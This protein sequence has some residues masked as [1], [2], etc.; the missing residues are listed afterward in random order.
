MMHWPF[1]FL[2]VARAAIERFV[3]SVRYAGVRKRWW[4]NGERWGLGGL[5]DY[6]VWAVMLVST[7]FIHWP[8]SKRVRDTKGLGWAFV[9]TVALDDYEEFARAVTS[10]L[11]VARIV[12]A[13]DREIVVDVV[14]EWNRL[15]GMRFALLRWLSFA[16]ERFAVGSE[17]VTVPGMKDGTAKAYVLARLWAGCMQ[18]SKIIENPDIDRALECRDLDERSR[19]DL[20]F[21]A[22]VS[23]ATTFKAGRHEPCWFSGLCKRSPILRY[24]KHGTEA[25]QAS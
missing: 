1:A 16:R 24:G 21:Y 10:P 12:D 18:A 7:S 9:H 13:V 2:L 22:G 20:F 25:L 4:G 5:S 19:K 14:A 3:V 8:L 6:S 11:E 15:F 17:R 23:A